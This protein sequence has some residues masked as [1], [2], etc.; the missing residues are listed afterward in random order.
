MR[1]KALDIA[2]YIINYS[3]EIERK[4]TNLKLQKLLYYVQAE[5]LVSKNERCFD[6]EIVSWDYGPVVIS[7]YDEFKYSG[8]MELQK[9]ENYKTIEFD[10]N[11]QNIKMYDKRFDDSYIFEKDKELIKKVVDSYKDKDAFYMVRK[12]HNE[13]PWKVTSKNQCINID[14]IQSYYCKYFNKIYGED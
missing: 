3:C 12:T 8:R 6:D 5:F 1:Y 2:R 10:E 9:Q 14:N 7:V 11:I 4:I 13:D